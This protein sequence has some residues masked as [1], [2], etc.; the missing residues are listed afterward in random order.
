VLEF[1]EGGKSLAWIG[2]ETAPQNAWR[3]FTRPGS[4]AVRVHFLT[5]FDPGEHPHRKAISAEARGR[6]RAELERQLGHPVD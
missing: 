6:I 5:P 1:D 3:V 4:F 2:E